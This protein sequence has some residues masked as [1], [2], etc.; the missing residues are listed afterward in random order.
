METLKKILKIIKTIIINLIIILLATIVVLI[1]WAM[2]QLNIQKKPYIDIFGYSIFSTATGSMYPTISE[3]DIVFVKIG[4]D[5]K[6]DDIITY[7]NDKNIITHRII[8]IKE[9]EIIAQG[10]NNNTPDEPIKKDEIIGKVAYIVKDVEVWRKVFSD[11]QVVIPLIITTILVILLV[12]YKE[13]TGE[14]DD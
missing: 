9:D 12:A 11:I 7:K 14:K 6:L 13:K 1:L 4:K 3:G 8:E 5:V 2:I 10:D